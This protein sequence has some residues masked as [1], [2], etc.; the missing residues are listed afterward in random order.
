LRE[1]RLIYPG[2]MGSRT[3]TSTQ[4][5]VWCSLFSDI[6]QHASAGRKRYRRSWE[7]IQSR[8]LIFAVFLL[9]W[10]QNYLKINYIFFIINI[11][12]FQGTAIKNTV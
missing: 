12:L 5:S 3:R 9:F 1:L 10:C 8:W 11:K 4:I 2:I 6:W 7:W